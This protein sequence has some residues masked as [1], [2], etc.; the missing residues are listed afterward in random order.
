MNFKKGDRV[1]LIRSKREEDYCSWNNCMYDHVDKEGT[2]EEIIYPY[3]AIATAVTIDGS[4]TWWYY[5]TD[6]LHLIVEEIMTKEVEKEK[7]T[8][9]ELYTKL[10]NQVDI[11]V[12]DTVKL[13]AYATDE[14]FG[15]NGK[16]DYD[17]EHKWENEEIAIVES[18][19]NTYGY[20]LKF[21][22]DILDSDD[23]DIVD[24]YFVPFFVIEKTDDFKFELIKG[25][26]DY[27]AF[28]SEYGV[29]VGC[30]L[31]DLKT[32]IEVGEAA[33]KFLKK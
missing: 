6:A 25:V 32:A 9:R 1:K 18:V 4:S 7:L 24:T 16:W 31:I 14:Q 5:P 15:W 21:V 10:Q 20:E 30:Q 26:G 19:G 22:N 28:I 17:L 12:G 33:T 11:K 27:K 8:P 3:G 23:I 2:V 29:K 13:I